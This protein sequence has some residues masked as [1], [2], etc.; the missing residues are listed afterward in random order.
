[1][2]RLERVKT[3]K[4]LADTSQDEKLSV[5]I[6]DA[7]QEFIDYCNRKNADDIPIS[8]DSV[9]VQMVIFRYNLLNTEG[10]LTQTYSGVSQS[11]ISEYPA[12]IM[13][14]LNRYRKLKVL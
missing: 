14:Q 7:E 10:I 1:M 3:I 12:Y 8:A 5:L 6:E 13:A 11:Y 4:G 2:T 9:I